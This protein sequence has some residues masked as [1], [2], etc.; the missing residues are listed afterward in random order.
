MAAVPMLD[1]RHT[2][3]LRAGERGVLTLRLAPR[4]IDVALLQVVDGRSARMAVSV[5]TGTYELHLQQGNPERAGWMRLWG[6]QDDLAAVDLDLA[7]PG[8]LVWASANA[9][10]HSVALQS[11]TWDGQTATLIFEETAP[12]G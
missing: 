5:H 12:A 11:L 3:R 8:H 1:E 2:L 7:R 6:G 10:I 4:T 9:E